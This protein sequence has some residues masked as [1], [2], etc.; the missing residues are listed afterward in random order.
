MANRIARMRILLREH[1]EAVD[2]PSREHG[3]DVPGTGVAGFSVFL[4]PVCVSV[5]LSHCLSSGM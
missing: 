1:L 5:C 3:A 4:S 2:G